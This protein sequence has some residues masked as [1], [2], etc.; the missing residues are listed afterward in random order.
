MK[1]RWWLW[2]IIVAALLVCLPA[3]RERAALERADRTVELVLDQERLWAL[4]EQ[5]GVPIPAILARWRE[6][7]VTALAAEDFE[8]ARLAAEAGLR[9]VPRDLQVIVLSRVYGWETG[10]VIFTGNQVGGYPDRLASTA[11][12][13]NDLGAPLGLIEFANQRGAPQLARLLNYRAVRVH[14]ITMEELARLNDADAASRYARAARERN[15]RVL[16]I[17]PLVR[18]PAPEMLARNEAYLTDIMA[19]LDEA[20][21]APG[22]AQPKPFWSTA[23]WVPAAAALA[24]AAGGCLL[25]SRLWAMPWWLAALGTAVSGG[26][27]YGLGRM[28][29]TVLARQTAALA[30]ALVFPALAVITAAERLRPLDAGR[31]H[32]APA[33]GWHAA[34]GWG[35]ALLQFAAVTLVGA[36][37]VAA[38]L[39]DTRFLLQLEQFRGVKLAHV[40]PL[41]I[42]V[43]FWL[44]DQYRGSWWQWLNAPLRMWHVLAG[45]AVLALGYVYVGRTGNDLVGVLDVERAMRMVLEDALEIRPRTKEFLLGYPALLLAF[46]FWTAGPRLLA[47]PLLVAGT[48]ASISVINTFAHAHSP[49][50]VSAVRTAYGFAAGLAVAVLA[51][52]A[53]VL[54][55]RLPPVRRWLAALADSGGRSRMTVPPDQGRSVKVVP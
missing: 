34:A 18:G 39:G 14:S 45:A 51:L 1:R 42:V 6:L 10:P 33:G 25:L 22:A 37:L 55:R 5:T 19:R 38:A 43:V 26:L 9:I 13:L 4:S 29:Y 46:G 50:A 24:A 44:A 32:R 36:G 20:G 21:L 30:V 17:R 52:A 49:L 41:F 15:A 53:V 16:Y 54:L 35:V 47:W 27:V 31:G 23:L 8:G 12:L 3:L 2:A 7:G 28:G 11:A 48:I 40:A